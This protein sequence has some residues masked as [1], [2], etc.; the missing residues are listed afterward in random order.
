MRQAGAVSN[1]GSGWAPPESASPWEP[2]AGPPLVAEPPAVGGQPAASGYQVGTPLGG[3]QPVA[4]EHREPSQRRELALTAILLM[5]AILS[6]LA[7]LMSWRDY[8]LLVGPVTDESGWVLPDGTM[9]RGWIAVVLGV[10]LAVAGVLVASD[11]LR[12]GRVFA[13]IGGIGLILLPILEWGLGAGR[14]RTGPGSGLWVLLF[15]GVVVVVAVGVLGSPV[16][17]S[18]RG[19]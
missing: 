19:S 4:V 6:G 5:A 14:A 11:R 16:P 3:V 15:V 8:G 2:P 18:D 9:G 17:P 12:S 10:V 1:A 7:S 13:L